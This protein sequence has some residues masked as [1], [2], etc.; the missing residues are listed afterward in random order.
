LGASLLDFWTSSATSLVF[1][2]VASNTRLANSACLVA[3]S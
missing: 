3:T 2:T 1:L